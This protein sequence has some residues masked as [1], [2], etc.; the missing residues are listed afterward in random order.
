MTSTISQSSRLAPPPS[1]T[2]NGLSHINKPNYPSREAGSSTYYDPTSEHRDGPMSWS[3]PGYASHSPIQVCKRRVWKDQTNNT[4][5]NRQQAPIFD[6]NS[7]VKMPRSTH[8]SPISARFP[9]LSPTFPNLHAHPSSR[10][11]SISQSPIHAVTSPRA[12]KSFPNGPPSTDGTLD[13]TVSSDAPHVNL[14]RQSLSKNVEEIKPT[15]TADPMSFSSILSSNTVDPPKSTVKQ[16]PP[17]KHLRKSSKLPNGDSAPSASM[18]TPSTATAPQK[19]SD[20]SRT[21]PKHDSS[22]QRQPAEDVK[23]PSL[24]SSSALKALAKSSHKDN[25]KV[26]KALA[27]IDAMELSDIESSE[28][29]GAKQQHLQRS[30]KRWLMVEDGEASKRKVGRLS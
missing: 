30:R 28:W 21:I 24:K 15:R 7:E 4:I 1:P 10:H 11:N 8:Q 29:L 14:R 26:Q 12:Q 25:E 5:K 6:K 18:S 9:Q 19:P 13:R 23:L 3:R 27:D 17:V 20:E 2:S 22:P 16:T